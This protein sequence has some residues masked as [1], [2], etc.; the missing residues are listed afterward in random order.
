MAQEDLAGLEPTALEN[1]GPYREERL[2]DSGR[3]DCR[4]ALRTGRRIVFVNDAVFGIAAAAARRTQS[5]GW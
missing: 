1:I 2:G 4:Q 3:L 5:P